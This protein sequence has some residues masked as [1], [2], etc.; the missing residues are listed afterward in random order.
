M[1]IQSVR[2]VYGQLWQR[3]VPVLYRMSSEVRCVRTGLEC[4]YRGTLSGRI[5]P[6][7]CAGYHLEKIEKPSENNQLRC[8]EKYFFKKANQNITI[9]E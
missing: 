8:I 2:A 6:D 3:K 7:W 5:C 4:I 1:F 9:K